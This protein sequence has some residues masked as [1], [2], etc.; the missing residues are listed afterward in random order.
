MTNP[1]YAIPALVVLVVFL[2]LHLQGKKRYAA[3]IQAMDK[4]EY[5][6]RDIMGVGFMLME[7]S[8]YQ[9]AGKL[10]RKARMQLRELYEPEFVEFYLRVQWGAGVTYGCLSLLLGT[11][12]FAARDGDVMLLALFV[13]LAPVL[14]YMSFSSLE[15][16]VEKR[17]QQVAM[18]LPD[19]TNQLIILSGAGLTLRAAIIKVGREMP[20]DTPFYVALRKAVNKMENGATDEAA[21][22]VLVTQC[23]MPVVRRLTSILL[24]N[25]Q[26]GGTDVLVAL[27]EIGAELW[28]NRKAAARQ[29]AEEVSTKMLF[30]M[31][32]MLIAVILL[33]AAPA[34][35][36]MNI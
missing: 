32:L 25:M 21:L 36:S 14:V 13:V 22:D 12:A 26:R 2:L 11:L 27:R 16:K 4:Q 5:G 28:T 20:G 3:M 6:L 1:I 34:V 33:V 9:Y 23:N 15:S 35:M 17:H 19:F 18:D 24:Q 10:D 29:M 7:L 8:K 31:M 30:P